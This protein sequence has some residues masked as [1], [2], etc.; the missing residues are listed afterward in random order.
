MS[1]LATLCNAGPLITVDGFSFQ[2]KGRTLRHLGEAESQILYMRGDLRFLLSNAMRDFSKDD[3]VQIW[4]KI[5]M[6][7]R[8]RWI[9]CKGEDIQRF[10]STLEGRIFS[11]W[12][13]SR[14]N[15]ID[16]DRA[17][18]LYFKGMDSS[19]EW[20]SR[21]KFA[22][23]TAT[24]ESDYCKM[25]RIMG[26]T[27]VTASFS[28]E[29]LIGRAQLFSSLFSEPFGYTLDQV[30][31]MTLGQ[32]SLVVAK[33]GTPYEDLNSEAN[34]ANQKQNMGIRRMRGTYTKAYRE[35]ALNMVEGR[36]LMSGLMS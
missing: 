14:H 1:G 27:R 29:Y 17:K 9:G 16:Y 18:D 11:F 26:L 30:A 2:L 8:F 35:M 23:E 4:E 15:G 25:Y 5:L 19:P 28:D 24:G 7:L 13:S 36:S 34:L 32:I 21:I 3:Q 31:D 33:R 22:I 20:E 12:Q 10:Y 6:K